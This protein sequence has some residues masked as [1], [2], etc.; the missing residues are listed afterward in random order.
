MPSFAQSKVWVS[1]ADKSDKKEASRPE[2]DES[3]KRSGGAPQLPAAM[4][5]QIKKVHEQIRRQQE[6]TLELLKQQDPERYEA[7]KAEQKEND[8]IDDIRQKTFSGK[9]TREEAESKLRRVIQ[10]NMERETKVLDKQIETLEKKLQVLKRERQDPQR[11]IDHR[12]QRIL[13]G[14]RPELPDV[15]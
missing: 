11:L 13:G 7:A 5:D 10:D 12:V 2:E 8:M 9:L 15:F 1:D 4:R 6:A 3:S 14:G